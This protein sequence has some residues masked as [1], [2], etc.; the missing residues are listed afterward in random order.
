MRTAIVYEG[1]HGSTAEIA[2]IIASEA[3][4]HGPVFVGEV[5]ET[6]PSR[7]DGVEFLVVGGPTHV[8][9]ECGDGPG[10]AAV[11]HVL[12]EAGASD[13]LRGWLDRLPSRPSFSAA[14]FDTR[15]PG[16]RVLTGASALGLYRAL[17]RHRC[18]LVTRPV[19]FL[20]AEGAEGRLLDGEAERAAEWAVTVMRRAE[21][22]Q[23]VHAG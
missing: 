8:L 15:N 16:L 12:R 18:H 4:G 9:A 6:S 20:V 10:G 5:S 13:G 19:S 1:M 7:L 11:A 22:F 2:Q 21:H 3:A 17:R 23:P 14:T